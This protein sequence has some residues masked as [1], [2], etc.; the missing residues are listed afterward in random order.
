MLDAHYYRLLEQLHQQ[1]GAV[2]WNMASMMNG[3]DTVD[4]ISFPKVQ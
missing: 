1:D 4:T 3:T 2:I